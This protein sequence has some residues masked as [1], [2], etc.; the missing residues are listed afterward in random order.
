ML[1]VNKLNGYQK[2]AI[3]LLS[4]DEESAAKVFSIMGEEEIKGI[5]FAMSNLG[6]VKQD[7]IDRLLFEFNTDISSAVSFIGNIETT[8]KLLE[9]VL[10]KDKVSQILEEI[11]GPAGKNTWDKLKNVSEDILASYL[12]NEYP[13]TIAFIISKMNPA[14]GAK[15]LSTLPEELSFNVITRVLNMESVKKEVTDSVERVLR[16]EFISTLSR[17]QKNDT[18]QMLAEIFNNFDRANEAKFMGMLERKVPEAAEKIKSLM[19]TFDDIAKVSAPSIQNILRVIDK[20]KLAVALKG[21]KDEVK[22]LFIS[23]MSQ[24]AAQILEEDMQSM[25]PIRVKD[26]D[27][28]QAAIILVVKDLINNGEVVISSGEDGDEFIY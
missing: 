27:E 6:T 26:V 20:S 19:F 10:G 3:L 15:L 25:G 14:Y 28:A 12:K 21:A 4:I 8:E 18:N 13:Q 16:L 24:R 11:S 23:N 22:S 1:D 9:K 17:S 5:S 2:A 7:T